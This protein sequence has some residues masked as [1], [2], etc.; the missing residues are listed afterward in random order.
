MKTKW[1]YL[2]GE[3]YGVLPDGRTAFNLPEFL[4]GELE[5]ADRPDSNYRRYG[6][7]AANSA[8][9]LVDPPLDNMVLLE[10]TLDDITIG[11]HVLHRFSLRRSPMPNS[12]HP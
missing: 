12:R 11:S 6:Y 4:V 2:D 1:Y 8:L 7:E 10:G 9:D 5:V 3:L